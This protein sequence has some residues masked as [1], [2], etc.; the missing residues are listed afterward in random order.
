MKSA[1]DRAKS[2]GDEPTLMQKAREV[3]EELHVCN[4]QVLK[5]PRR[6]IAELKKDMEA[7]RRG[8]MTDHTIATEKNIL[9]KIKGMLEQEE[10]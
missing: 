2:R 5:G 4:K 1:W 3:H 9:Q 10:I 7:L 8:S 6:H